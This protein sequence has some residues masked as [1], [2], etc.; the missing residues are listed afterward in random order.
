[1]N[2]PLDQKNAYRIA[3]IVYDEPIEFEVKEFGG[4]YICCKS[5]YQTCDSTNA[6]TKVGSRIEIIYTCTL[7]LE[8]VKLKTAAYY[9]MLIFLSSFFCSGK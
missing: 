6:W 8:Q 3:E 9:F 2:S 7:K 5:D 4:F 1:M